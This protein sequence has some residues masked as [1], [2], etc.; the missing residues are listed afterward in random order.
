MTLTEE[1]KRE[2]E[3]QFN[4]YSRARE[5]HQF[6]SEDEKKWNDAYMMQALREAFWALGYR[7][8]VKEEKTKCHITYQTYELVEIK[9]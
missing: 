7:F 6:L 2:I 4:S 9:K 3:E 1:Q 5:V 8:K